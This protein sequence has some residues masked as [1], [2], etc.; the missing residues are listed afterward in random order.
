M[1]MNS[2]SG[3]TVLVRRRG[4]HNWQE[5]ATLIKTTKNGWRIRWETG[6]RMGKTAN[7]TRRNWDVQTLFSVRSKGDVCP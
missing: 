5:G 6:F 1:P 7:L 2:N 4:W 3:F